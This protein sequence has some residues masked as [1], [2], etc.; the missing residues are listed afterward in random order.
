MKLQERSGYILMD[1]IKSDEFDNVMVRKSVK[2]DV[3]CQS[4][5][6]VFGVWLRCFGF[7]LAILMFAI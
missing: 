5:L 3:K 6:G 7:N 4:E 1:L 2:Y